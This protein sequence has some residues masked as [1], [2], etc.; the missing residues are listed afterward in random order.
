MTKLVLGVSFIFGFFI[1][2]SL[3]GSVNFK[4]STLHE[5][6]QVMKSQKMSKNLNVS[7]NYGRI[8]LYFVPNEGQVDKRALFY[9]KTPKYTLWLTKEGLIFDS[10]RRIK[11]ES[12]K[13]IRQNPRNKNTPEDFT[14]DRDVSRMIFVNANRSPEVIPMDDTEHKVNYFIGN[15]ESKWRTNVQTSSTILYKEL[16]PNIDLKVY[17]NE[18]QIEY[19]FIVKPGGEVSDIIFECKD[20]VSTEIDREGNL[21]TATKFGNLI[22][23]KP[24][25]Y[26]VIE[27]KRIEVGAEFGQIEMNTYS[28]E[29]EEYNGD[30]ELIIDPLVLA[31]STYLGGS[32]SDCCYGIAV[33][34]EG[35]AYITGYTSSSDFPTQI[36]IQ[37]DLAGSGDVFI[38]K[39]N[40]AGSALIYSTYLGGS[41]GEG[42]SG[43]AID[44]EGAVYVTG[45]TSSHDFPTVNPIQEWPEDGFDSIQ[46]TV[47][48]IECDSNEKKIDGKPFQTC[49]GNACIFDCGL[50]TLSF[51]RN[52]DAVFG[53][54]T[55]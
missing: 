43:I 5:S 3:W 47:H 35:A 53:N 51:S 45:D 18:K 10:T 1:F 32:D 6:Q 16:Y 40:S 46:N 15:D 7:P 55:D 39:I 31:Y 20:I 4:S 23:K 42:G 27:G 19:D 24:V 36:P 37:V 12:T 22:Q 49:R 30:Y 13:S 17:G 52:G 11:K 34:T 9:A 26:Q 50:K 14:Y 38:S 44:I 21:V 29:V 28:F 2:L 8:P 25:C 54:G 33:D 41:W 48:V